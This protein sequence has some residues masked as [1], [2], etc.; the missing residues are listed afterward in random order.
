MH[1]N[2]GN[3]NRQG[4]LDI[5]SYS[6]FRKFFGIFFFCFCFRLFQCWKYRRLCMKIDRIWKREKSTSANRLPPIVFL[7]LII[8]KNLIW[9]GCFIHMFHQF[10][11][12]F[13]L[14]RTL[15]KHSVSQYSME[16][17]MMSFVDCMKPQWDH[18][19]HFQTLKRIYHSAVQL[20]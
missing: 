11:L 17:L 15:K 16:S 7:V 10:S 5:W 9:N 2:I 12:P 14:H 20:S 19:S 6:G 8:L 1:L 4:G 13:L 3:R 18:Y